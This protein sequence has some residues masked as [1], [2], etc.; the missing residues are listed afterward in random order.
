MS[1]PP[2]KLNRKQIGYYIIWMDMGGP[3]SNLCSSL[4]VYWVCF[5]TSDCFSRARNLKQRSQLSGEKVRQI[6]D[7]PTSYRV[8]PWNTIQKLHLVENSAGRMFSLDRVILHPFLKNNIG[9]LFWFMILELIRFFLS[10]KYLKPLQFSV[11]SFSV[12]AFS[13]CIMWFLSCF[14]YFMF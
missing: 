3:R 6:C 7:K 11:Q 1:L 10:P 14:K 4:E 2:G 5:G 9:W 8:L 13:F 12:W